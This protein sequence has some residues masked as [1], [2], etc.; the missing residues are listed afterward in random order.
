MARSTYKPHFRSPAATNEPLLRQMI[1]TFCRN[2]G[3][4]RALA[5]VASR[6]HRARTP[7]RFSSSSPLQQRRLYTQASRDGSGG[8]D[9]AVASQYAIGTAAC[10]HGPHFSLFSAASDFIWL[11]R[12]IGNAS[13]RRRAPRKF[14]QKPRLIGALAAASAVRTTRETVR[15]K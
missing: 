10:W 12:L 6:T 13:P 7:L 5:M 11:V 4:W 14:Q 15:I 9:L 3:V 2:D 1:G 8:G